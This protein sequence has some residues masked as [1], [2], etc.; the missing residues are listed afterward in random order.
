MAG[1]NIG[2]VI[3]EHAG[4]LMAISGVVGVGA[5]ESQG[6]QCIVIF[7]LDKEADSLR[8]LPD[9]I[10]GYLLTITESGEFQALGK[11]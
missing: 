5:G 9:S 4:E 6:N 8:A 10:A 1:K 2:D 3:K 11:Q 7:V